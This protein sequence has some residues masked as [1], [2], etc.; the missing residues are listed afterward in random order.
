MSGIGWD[1]L[2]PKSIEFES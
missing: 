2:Y 1:D